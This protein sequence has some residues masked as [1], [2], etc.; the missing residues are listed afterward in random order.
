MTTRS[1]KL[2][3]VGKMCVFHGSQ[4]KQKENIGSVNF[5]CLVLQNN[6]CC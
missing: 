3:N 4:G 6:F 5:K 2:I 1:E